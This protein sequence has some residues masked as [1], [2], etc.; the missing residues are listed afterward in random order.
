MRKLFTISLVC[1]LSA[2]VQAQEPVQVEYFLD[3]DPGYGQGHLITGIGQGPNQLTFDFGDA[4]PGAHVLSVRTQ[5]SRGIWSQTISRPLY[6]VDRKEAQQPIRIEYFIDS[7]PGHGKGISVSPVQ[8]GDNPLTF[9]VSSAGLGPHVL[10]VRSQ[11][12]A[13][14]WSETM[15]RPFYVD[16]TPEIVYIEYFIDNDPGTGKGTPIALPDSPDRTQMSLNLK[17]NTAELIGGEH[18]FF[19]RGLDELGRWTCLMSRRFTVTGYVEPEITADDKTREYGDENPELTYTSNVKLKGTPVLTTTA[20]KTSPV[21]EY[22]IA[23]E[24]GTVEGQF[25]T[26]KGKLTV[27]KAPLT[28][29]GGQ[30]TMKQGE[31]MPVFHASYSGF[32]NGETESVLTQQPVLTTDATSAS[33]P[34]TYE[35][36]VNGASADNYEIS[37]TAGT[38]HIEK[39]DLVTVT[40]LSY[41]REYGEE[42]PMFEFTS[43]GADLKGKPVISCKATATSPVGTY[44]IVIEKGGV[45]NYNDSYVNGTLTITKAP[46]KI[47]AGNYT[48]RQGQMNPQFTLTYEGFKNG[49]TEDVLTKKPVVTT[50]ATLTSPVGSYEVKVSG[51]EAENYDI[52]YVNGTLTVTT[53]ELVGQKVTRIEYFFDED[54]GYG[55]GFVLEKPENGEHD[56]LMSFESLDD[57]IHVLSL[58]AQDDAGHWSQTISR[59]LYIVDRKEAQQPIRIEYFIDSDPGHGKGISVSPVQVGDNPLTFDVSSAAPGPHVLSVRSQDAAGRWSETMSRP[60]F[61]DRHPEIVYVEYFIDEDPGK[62][63]GT[64]VALPDTPDKTQLSLDLEVY[65]AELIG[66]EHVFSVRAMDALGSWTNLMSRQFTIIGYVEPEITADDKTR[67]YGDENPE[68]TY[69]TNVTVKG[70]PVLTTTATKTSPAGE[71]EITVERGTVEGK[72]TTVTGKLTITKAPLTSSGCEYTIKQREPMPTFYATYAGFKNGETEYVLTQMPTLE[73]SATSGS[74]PGTYEITVSGAQAENYEIS[75]VP[76][77]LTILEADPVTITAS[78]FTREYGEENPAFEFTS[79]GAPLEGMPEIS[80]EATATSPVGTYPIIIKKGGVTNY[81]DSYVNGTLT[82]TKAPLKITAGD[83]TRMQGQ[84][85]PEFTLT[86]EGFKN[87]ETEDVLTKKPVATTEATLTSPV[88]IYEVT[89]SGAEADNYDISYVNGTLTVTTAELVGERVTR[90][91]YFF[92]NDPGYGKGFALE[93]PED[94]EHTYIMSFESLSEGVHL[95]SLRAQD[96]VGHWSQTLS[97][98][99]Y[100][101]DKM[102]AQQPAVI[103][104]FFD[105]DPGY[106]QGRTLDQLNL[107]DNLLS[108]DISG[109]ESGVHVLSL[110]SQDVAG[111]W[112]STLSR[113]VYVVKPAGEVVAVEYFFD[114]DPG[115]GNGISVKLPSDLSAPFAIDIPVDML[116][117][118]THVFSI[119]SK[120]SNGQWSSVRSEEIEVVET[121]GIDR[122]LMSDEQIDVYDLRGHKVDIGTYSHRRRLEKGVYIINGRKVIVK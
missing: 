85:N 95:L 87:G 81:N 39:A 36:K 101:V 50:D 33:S 83:Y 6:I 111:R 35:V 58:R 100:V 110:R 3:A 104:Y 4:A 57:G 89:V 28:I 20:T 119:R 96:D 31:A 107:G 9:D 19:V 77:T 71:Y 73:T 27:T 116:S 2:V 93:K 15:S 37:Y 14:R 120:D 70:T 62:G 29:S 90:I 1:L 108:L 97:R 118:G 68:L 117:M 46:L 82:I 43:S 65:T 45:E 49:E 122:I 24:R 11:D 38:L 47:T 48:R 80:C 64:P 44:P 54:P 99:I 67:E 88:G 61:V 84:M 113:P 66:G 114:A 30:Y 17:V 79:A 55:N 115:C 21:G 26:V 72:F 34:G 74:T 94:G 78:S 13:G 5:D 32:K 92:D 75:Y 25:T 18:E 106:G 60:F 76:G 40:A 91:E 12:A 102:E 109:I 8:V 23:V 56:Y 51:A 42:N 10:G 63:K 112:S 105:E 53:A 121:S 52:S 86:Y 69:T 59:P 103:E 7:D 41:T 98:P 16:R 22:E